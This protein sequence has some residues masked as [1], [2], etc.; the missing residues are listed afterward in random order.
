MQAV[1]RSPARRISLGLSAQ[2]STKVPEAAAPLPASA[3]TFMALWMETARPRR[4]RIWAARACPWSASPPFTKEE[5]VFANLGDGTYFHSGSLA[6]RQA[7]RLR[8]QHHLQDP[9]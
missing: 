8:R 5:H 7:V 6:I 2:H 3:A 4:L 1:R 9:L